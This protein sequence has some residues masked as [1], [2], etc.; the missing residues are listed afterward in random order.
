MKAAATIVYNNVDGF[1]AIYAAC[2]KKLPFITI[3]L[4]Q[5]KAILPASATSDE[6][7]VWGG[8]LTVH[9]S[10]ASTPT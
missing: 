5:M 3:R 7:G 1:D 9:G 6:N 4:D 2:T 8:K 10:G